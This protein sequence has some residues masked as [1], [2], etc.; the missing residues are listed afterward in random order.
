MKEI[1]KGSRRFHR[2]F[3]SGGLELA[4]VASG[5]LDS[6]AS[7]WTNPWDLSAGVLLVREANGIA[8]NILGQESQPSYSTNKE[9][10]DPR[11]HP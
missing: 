7:A 10:L 4:W 1:T 2:E 6:Y 9:G 3:Q 5:K 8:T 11:L